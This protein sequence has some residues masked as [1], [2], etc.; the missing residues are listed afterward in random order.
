MEKSSTLLQEEKKTM[1]T[2]RPRRSV[3]QNILNY[4]KSLQVLPAA[5]LGMSFLLLNN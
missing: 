2:E 1:K 4:S 5:N 3:I